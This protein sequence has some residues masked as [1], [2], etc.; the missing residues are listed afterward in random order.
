LALG[1]DKLKD[2]GFPGLG[3]GQGASQVLEARRTAPRSFSMIATQY[4]YKYGLSPAEVKRIIGRIAVQDHY[5]GRLCPEAH[6]HNRVT[7]EQVMSAPIIPWPPG[8]SDCCGNSEGGAAALLVP[9]PSQAR[10]YRGDPIYIKGLGEAHFAP[11]PQ[12][13]PAFDWLHFDEVMTQRR[14]FMSCLTL[15]RKATPREM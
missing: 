8:L 10:R 1:V 12:N 15:V 11:L 3:T 14:F 4:L 7:L 9:A 13:H 5:S 2:T 6:L